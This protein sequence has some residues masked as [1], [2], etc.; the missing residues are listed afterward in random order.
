MLQEEPPRIPRT[1]NVQSCITATPNHIH[2]P[3]QSNW[4]WHLDLTDV[5]VVW[6]R[7]K[8]AATVDGF[9]R[10]IVV[11]HVFGRRPTMS[12]LVGLIEQAAEK[13]EKVFRSL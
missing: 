10:K 6:K 4:V 9:S 7:F 11:L 1:A 2:H 8:I 12:D 3:S 5:R 13:T